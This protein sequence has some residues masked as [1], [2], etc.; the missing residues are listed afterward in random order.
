MGIVVINATNYPLF[1]F[2]AYYDQALSHHD[3][4][5]TIGQSIG[6]SNLLHCGTLQLLAC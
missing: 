3:S 4:L 5:F 6:T 1:G 2:K